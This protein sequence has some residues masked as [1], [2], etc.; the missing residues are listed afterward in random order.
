M[1]IFNLFSSQF[2]DVI[3]WTQADDDTMVYRFPRYNN[4]I[5]YGAKLTV[6]E[7]Q[8]AILV[9]EGKIADVFPPGIY[10]LKTA[11]LPILS[12][13]QNWHH[14]FESPFKAEVYFFN[15]TDFLNQKW[16]T[17]QPV[18]LSDKE[19]GVV[20]LRAFGTYTLRIKAP[21]TLLKKLVGTDGN[22]EINEVSEQITNSIATRFPEIIAKRQASILEL[23][24]RYRELANALKHEVQSEATQYG[25]EIGDIFIENISLP[26]EV[27]KVL[28][29]KTGMNIIGDD[30]QN[31]TRYQ[32]AK[33]MGNNGSGSDAAAA[34]VGMAVGMEMA[35]ELR[36]EGLVLDGHP[37]VKAPP[38]VYYLMILGEQKGPMSIA[39][40][41]TLLANGEASEDTLIWHKG[42]HEWQSISKTEDIDLSQLPPPPPTTK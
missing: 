17:K 35:K 20:R 33:G 3:D 42:M 21:K 9:N 36:E 15:N 40:V 5:K 10:E 13:L 38:K 6:R 14:G 4:E 12:N 18:T 39:E 11:N 7:G 24:T 8:N 22:F 19:F 30:M 41:Y 2:V 29:E 31:Y 16:G 37:A 25:L 1:G 27:Q 26:E 23:P 32:T 28:D 34:G